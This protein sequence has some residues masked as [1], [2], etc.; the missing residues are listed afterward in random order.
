MAVILI[1]RVPNRPSRP[2]TISIPSARAG[3]VPDAAGPR[4]RGDFLASQSG[5]SGHSITAN[6]DADLQKVGCASRPLRSVG[7]E[8]A[9]ARGHWVGV[10]DVLDRVAP[11]FRISGLEGPLGS[12]SHFAGWDPERK[13]S[14]AR[15]PLEPHLRQHV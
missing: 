13:I 3:S 7:H 8:L 6:I 5:S 15:Q 11:I 2:K 10:D 1:V 14:H 12:K 9:H 4:V